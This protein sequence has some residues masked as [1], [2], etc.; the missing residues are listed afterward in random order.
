[1]NIKT[2]LK[3]SVAAAALF[4]VAVPVAEAGTVSNG[5]GNSVTVSGQISKMW[6]HFDDGKSERSAVVDN[7]NSG[8]RFR[9][10]G[11]GK[12]NEAVSVGTALEVE[13][14]D[15]ASNNFTVADGSAN[16]TDDAGDAFGQTSF[17]QR[18]MEAFIS[19]KQFGKL[20]IGQ[21]PTASDGT[22]EVGLSGAY[23]AAG[24]GVFFVVGDA[25]IRTANQADNVFGATT[26]GDQMTNLDGASRSDRV[27]YDTPTFAGF[28]IAASAIS[29]GANDVAVRYK[30]KF[31]G[32]AV[33]GA[34]SYLNTSATSTSVD[35]QWVVSAAAK[36]DSGLN[37]RGH[38]GKAEK[39]STASNDTKAYNISGGYDASLTSMGTTAFAVGYTVTK[40]LAAN[41]SEAE[42]IDF[43]V[44][45]HLKDAGTELY[46][47]V[48]MMSFD[49]ATATSYEDATAIFAGTRIKF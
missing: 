8:S 32:V 48:Q 18:R 2:T 7:D 13:F 9:I 10:L 5:N 20:S 38:Y 47:G 11:S 39:T 14:Q 19:H 24:G 4:A 36:H 21:G 40:D 41:G 33:A 37:M 42:M 43:G 30:G 23:M 45:Q 25:H 16:A 6:M 49:D 22:A 17:A 1:M 26:W 44:V 29:G 3:T 12:V 35:N 34:A 27:R 28:S 31:G 15:N 46:V